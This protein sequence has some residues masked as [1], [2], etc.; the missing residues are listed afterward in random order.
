MVLVVA[1]AGAVVVMGW[2][3]TITILSTGVDEGHDGDDD[4]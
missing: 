3:R 1:L 4:R 2:S